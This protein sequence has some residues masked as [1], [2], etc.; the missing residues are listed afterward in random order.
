MRDSEISKKIQ[1]KE[2]FKYKRKNTVGLGEKD[3]EK[4]EKIKSHQKNNNASENKC[5][6]L[7][8]PNANQDLIE[9]PKGP[10]TRARTKQL[11]KDLTALLVRIWDDTK[12]FDIGEA[13]DNSLKAQYTL[14]QTDFSS[15]PALPAQFSSNQLT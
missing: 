13:V 14:L 4:T 6:S 2:E 9:L 5:F 8:P 7:A 1:P 15:S 10:I 11:Q 12:S 3:C